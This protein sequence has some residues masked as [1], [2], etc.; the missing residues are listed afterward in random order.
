MYY[1]LQIKTV[2]PES[3]KLFWIV[4]ILIISGLILSL[5]KKKIKISRLRLLSAITIDIEKN[6]TYHPVT[7]TFSITNREKDAIAI[8]HPVLRF[9]QGRNRKAYKIKSVNAKAIY[10]LFLETNKT[11]VLPVSLQ[12]FYEYEKNLKRFSKLR[13]EFTYNRNRFKKSEYVLLKPTLFKKEK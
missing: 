6:K 9:K 12:P 4:L 10:P 3:Y 2:G 8:E 13:I 7:V 1:L 5:S 11:H